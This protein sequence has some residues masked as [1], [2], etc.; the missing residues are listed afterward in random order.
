MDLRLPLRTCWLATTMIF[1]AVVLSPPAGLGASARGADRGIYEATLRDLFRGSLPA[2]FVIQSMPLSLPQPSASDWNWFGP[3]T[4]TL[5]ATV[6]ATAP[7]AA[8]PFS[9][10][11]FPAGTTLMSR[12]DLMAFFRNAPNLNDRWGAFRERFKVTAFEGFSRPATTDAGLDA[13]VYYSHSCGS[14]CGESGFAWLHRS[15][16]TATWVVEKRLPKVV[17]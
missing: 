1:L 10:E 14:L 13:L 16:T 17:S 11:L 3:A 5:Q 6:E 15:S 4:G 9:S 12:E 2:A 8:A 7:V